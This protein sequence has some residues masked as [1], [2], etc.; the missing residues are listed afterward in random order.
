MSTKILKF[1]TQVVQL[2]LNPTIRGAGHDIRSLC[3]CT[4]SLQDGHPSVSGFSFVYLFINFMST[5]HR[6]TFLFVSRYQHIFYDNE[7][8][9]LIFFLQ[10]SYV[11]SFNLP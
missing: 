2:D 11:K 10:L 5:I 1:I 9:L 3:V 7:S 6:I 8:T 4:F